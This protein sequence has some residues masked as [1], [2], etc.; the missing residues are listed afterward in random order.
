MLLKKNL[1]KRNRFLKSNIP[2]SNLCRIY[3]DI[4]TGENCRPFRLLTWTSFI[5]QFIQKKKRWS[6]DGYD[7]VDHFSTSFALNNCLQFRLL[8]WTSFIVL[9][10]DS[11]GGKGFRFLFLR[12]I[13]KADLAR[14][15]RYSL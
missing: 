14:F 6:G 9:L 12:P 5:G 7:Y 11:V 10:V 2:V 15:L 13:Q 1:Q 8:T 3:V 4:T